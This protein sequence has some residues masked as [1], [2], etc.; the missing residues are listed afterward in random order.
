M[1]MRSILVPWWAGSTSLSTLDMALAIA[2]RVEA[3]LDV[4]FV[5]PSLTDLASTIG[6]IA[7]PSPA[8]LRK[9]E[10]SAHEAETM[11]RASFDVWRTSNDLPGHM[12]DM[13]LRVPFAQWSTREGLPEQVVLRRGRLTDMTVLRFPQPSGALDNSIDAALFESGHPLLLVPAHVNRPPLDHVVVAW[14]G[15]L[16]ATRAVVG[17]ID[18]LRSAERVTVLTTSDFDGVDLDLLNGLTWH[19]IEAA[20]HQI[21]VGAVTLGATLLQEAVT[22]GASLLVMGA[23]THSRV[24]AASLGGVTKHLFTNPPEIPVMLAH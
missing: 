3:H 18:L 1:A 12:V 22:L 4:V 6:S 20:R 10:Q 7:N 5:T 9:I 16:Y 15:S 14:N 17:A 19:G 2:R 24:S 13:Q 23:F 11:A 21:D 8:I